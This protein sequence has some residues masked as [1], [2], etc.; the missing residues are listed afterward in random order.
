M[1]W[2][3]SQTPLYKGPSSVEELYNGYLLKLSCVL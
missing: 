1:F 3:E 2:W